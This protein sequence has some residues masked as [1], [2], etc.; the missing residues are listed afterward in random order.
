MN[1]LVML[2]QLQAVFA[3]WPLLLLRPIYRH[4][5]AMTFFN[6]PPNSNPCSIH[7]K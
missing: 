3:M 7:S 2:R 5:H 6:A 4:T 1:V